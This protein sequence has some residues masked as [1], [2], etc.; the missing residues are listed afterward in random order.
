MG[1]ASHS[2]LGSVGS[3]I[4]P[5][6]IEPKHLRELAPWREKSHQTLSDVQNTMTK[7]VRAPQPWGF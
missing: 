3:G 1:A 7:T 2:R 4:E 5:L 6:S